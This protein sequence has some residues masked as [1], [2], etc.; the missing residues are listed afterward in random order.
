MYYL[1]FLYNEP[2]NL[3]LN[4]K[5]YINNFSAYLTGLIEG[6]GHI[7]VPNKNVTSYN[8]FVAVDH[9]LAAPALAVAM[10]ECDTEPHCDPPVRVLKQARCR[11]HI[12]ICGPLPA[13]LWEGGCFRAFVKKGCGRG[14]SFSP[15][16][17]LTSHISDVMRGR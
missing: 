3:I 6:D 12:C 8:P 17:H 4:N 1:I 9:S 5:F 10:R 16:T 11:S 13:A 7:I 2:K 14:D 15:V